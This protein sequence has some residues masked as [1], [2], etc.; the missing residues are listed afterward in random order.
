V[1]LVE[2]PVGSD[3]TDTVKVEIRGADEGLVRVA[4]PGQVIARASRSLGDMLAS[5]RPVA[6]SFV[7]S[8]QG[9]A[10]APDEITVEFGIALNAE[11]DAIIT[12][13]SAEANFS[14]SLVWK[15]TP[16]AEPA[17]P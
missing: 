16:P 1:Y 12:S 14:V 3:E 17:Q 9:L 5:V 13:T 15:R 4:R 2:L 7:H 11:A 6:E 10:N 8:F